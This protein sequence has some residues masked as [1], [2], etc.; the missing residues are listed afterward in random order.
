MQ[1]TGIDEECVYRRGSRLANR[2]R[3]HCNS[4]LTLRSRATNANVSRVRN[5]H[6][7]DVSTNRVKK[8]IMTKK[9]MYAPLH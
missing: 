1:I 4:V 3:Y 8:I 7:E 6:D 9:C 5:L 2:V